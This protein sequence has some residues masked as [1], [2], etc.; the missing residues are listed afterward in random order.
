MLLDSKDVKDFE[1]FMFTVVCLFN[2][3]FWWGPCQV[4]LVQLCLCGS[5]KTNSEVFPIL[6]F[7]KEFVHHGF[8]FAKH[9]IEFYRRAGQAIRSYGREVLN[10]YF[11]FSNRYEVIWV[12]YFFSIHLVTFV[13]REVFPCCICCQV[14]LTLVPETLP[15]LQHCFCC[16][17]CFN[18][19][20][21][22][23]F[24][25]HRIS[26]LLLQSPCGTW[27]CDLPASTS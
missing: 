10:Y 11:N 26:S 19:G 24:R 3:I 15:Y 8:F 16:C 2:F 18:R 22:L 4:L 7:V 17:C 23:Y 5:H 13:F 20:F 21:V 9:L 1:P 12:I 6:P 25:K 27:N 14:F